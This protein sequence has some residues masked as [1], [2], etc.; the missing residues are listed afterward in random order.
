MPEKETYLANAGF[1]TKTVTTAKQRQQV[2]QL[3]AG[4][5]SMVQYHDA[6]PKSNGT[7]VLIGGKAHYQTYKQQVTQARATNATSI[8]IDPDPHGVAV[9]EFDGFGPMLDMR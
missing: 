3:P 6:Y 1:K 2:S 7:E 5:V 9:R 4:K 8:N